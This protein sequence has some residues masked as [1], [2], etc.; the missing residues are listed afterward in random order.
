[1]KKGWAAS[2]SVLGVFALMTAG[3]SSGKP[4]AGPSSGAVL[5]T[6]PVVSGAPAPA[7]ISIQSPSISAMPPAMSVSQGATSPTGIN[8]QGE[9]SVKIKPDTAM[10]RLGVQLKADTA[11][12][13]QNEAASRM[14]A[15]V[16]KLATM[17][18]P[19]DAIK[20]ISFSLYP[21]YSGG[22]NIL[23]GF[24]V[25]NIVSFT[26]RDIDKVGAMLDA[27][28]AAGA[29]SIQQVAFTIN[30]PEPA[31]VQAR[32]LAMTDARR[33][34]EQLARLAGV[35]LG[36]AIY[37]SDSTTSPVPMLRGFY[38][39]APMPAITTPISPGEMEVQV[40]VQIVYD[41]E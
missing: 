28:V 33:K 26:S 34:A 9:G 6:G 13:A 38:E 25:R 36:K 24:S 14:D 19:K 3:C 15:M 37:I 39:A 18:V 17:G 31:K 30:D 20:T 21:D 32:E 35:R 11:E 40:R 8:V 4:P 41:I 22:G 1:M 10:L 12:R 7:E 16:Q 23:T 29:N 2:L 5:P 27:A